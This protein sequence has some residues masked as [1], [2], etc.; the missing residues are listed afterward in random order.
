[1]SLLLF[2]SWCTRTVIIGPVAAVRG[3][4]TEECTLLPRVPDT[5]KQILYAEGED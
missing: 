2:G 3:L 4:Y 5:D 1:V